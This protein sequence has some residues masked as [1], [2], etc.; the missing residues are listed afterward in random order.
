MRRIVLSLVLMT[1]TH[2]TLRAQGA[3]TFH[4]FPQIADGLAGNTA[5]F[6]TLAAVNV[7]PQP[8]TC[9]VRLYGG[10]AGRIASPT[11]TLTPSGGVGGPNTVLASGT[12]LPLA[13]GY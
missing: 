6:S 2:L 8:A 11:F 4:V 13:T 12:I 5:Y 1:V 7:S 10:V 9:T 3:A